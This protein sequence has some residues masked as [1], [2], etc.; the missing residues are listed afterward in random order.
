MKEITR[1]L[2]FHVKLLNKHQI[3]CSNN[4]TVFNFRLF[5]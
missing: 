2:L 5:S 4:I 1:N 3:L